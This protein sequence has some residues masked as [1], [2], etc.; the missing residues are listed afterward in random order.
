MHATKEIWDA[1]SR[2]YP[3]DII[4]KNRNNSTGR[5]FNVDVKMSQVLS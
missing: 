1:M 4:D 2:N 5:C 3:T